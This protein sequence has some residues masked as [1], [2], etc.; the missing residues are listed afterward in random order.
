LVIPGS[1]K[2]NELKWL[3]NEEKERLQNF[4][5]KTIRELKELRGIT[6]DTFLRICL[7]TQKMTEYS[8]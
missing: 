8:N 7:L 4:A 2:L 1:L 6:P 3:S 5:P